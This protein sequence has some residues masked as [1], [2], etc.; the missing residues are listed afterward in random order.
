MV[1]STRETENFFGF[2]VKG[3][4]CPC[5]GL[6]CQRLVFDPAGLR[7]FGVG[8]P[9]LV[10]GAADGAAARREGVLTP[11]ADAPCF[12]GALCARGWGLGG[13]C[14]AGG[15]GE[16]V[17]GGC[18]ETR[19]STSRFHSLSLSPTPPL[20]SLTGCDEPEDIHVQR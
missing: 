16:V 18:G 7:G 13:G 19:T 5:E 8:D 1:C 9:R 14:E 3:L 12:L 17:G 4:V 10:V 11:L 20:H 2:R 15:W 6:G